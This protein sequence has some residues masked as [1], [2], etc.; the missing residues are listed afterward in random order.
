MLIVGYFK[1]MSWSGRR[2]SSRWFSNV[3]GNRPQFPVLPRFKANPWN[4]PFYSM[5]GLM[6]DC[7]NVGRD[8]ETVFEIRGKLWGFLGFFSRA[9]V[10]YKR[11]FSRRFLLGGGFAHGF[12]RFGR[13][14]RL[15]VFGTWRVPLGGGLFFSDKNASFPYIYRDVFR[16][17]F[18]MEDNKFTILQQ[19]RQYFRFKN[20]EWRQ[21]ERF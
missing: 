1:C 5:R 4:G 13:R 11:R 2:A 7:A 19:R 20:C 12:S 6:R 8:G 3:S 18:C 10:R 14:K 17:G 9:A 16:I 15:G 21:H